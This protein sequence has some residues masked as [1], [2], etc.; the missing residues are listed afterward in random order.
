MPLLV[1]WMVALPVN[2]IGEGVL[3]E[4]STLEEVMAIEHRPS[5]LLPPIPPREHRCR[6]PLL[7]GGK[8]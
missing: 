7:E 8:A 5:P 1:S 4:Y 6:A 2:I 3:G